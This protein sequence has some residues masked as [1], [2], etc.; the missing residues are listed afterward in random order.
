MERNT[1][2]YVLK[3]RNKVVYVG[4]TD[5]PDRREAEHRLDKDF[6]SMVKIGNVSSR[7]GAELWETERIHQ[8]MKNHDGHTPKY[9]QNTSGK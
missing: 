6:D 7:Q 9:N 8:Y 3:K 2:K 5:D 1:T 4:I